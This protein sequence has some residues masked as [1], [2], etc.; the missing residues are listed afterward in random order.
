MEF[1]AALLEGTPSL[2]QGDLLVGVPFAIFSAASA[3]VG[4]NG[5]GTDE[6]DLTQNPTSVTFVA[7]AVE[8]GWGL[9]LTQTCDLQPAP[10]T[11]A[12]RKPILIARVRPIKTL[13][14][15]FKDDTLKSAVG[16]VKKL[17]TAGSAP[18]LF[19]LPE[20]RGIALVFEKS[21]A[22][23]LDLQRFDRTDLAALSRLLRLRLAAPALQAL[24]ERCAYCFGRFAAPDD[25]YYSAD[26]FL[27]L[28]RQ[29]EARHQSL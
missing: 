20:H 26:E 28:Q 19:Y 12:A 10:D 1:Y 18:S 5:G 27:E 22:D 9:V 4:L 16:E 3:R 29:E 11:G 17:A 13:L 14:P 15:K 7:A 2:Q 21:G 24:Q 8:F 23:L 6:R 25:L